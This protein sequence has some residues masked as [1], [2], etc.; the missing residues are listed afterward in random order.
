MGRTFSTNWAMEDDPFMS[1]TNSAVVL[2]L[3]KKSFKPLLKRLKQLL[4]KK[5]TRFLE[6][7]LNLAK[8]VKKSTERS[9][10]KKKSLTTPAKITNAPWIQCKLHWKLNLVPREKLSVSRRS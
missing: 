9:M 5:K 2:K 6:H 10:R 1:L 3:R 7:S 4:S 8:F